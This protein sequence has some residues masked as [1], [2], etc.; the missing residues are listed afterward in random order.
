MP[1][2]PWIIVRNEAGYSVG[3]LVLRMSI[4][5]TDP[6]T[7]SITT[8]TF[9]HDLEGNMLFPVGTATAVARRMQLEPLD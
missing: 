8:Q 9:F 6:D 2:K 5:R 7:L 3:F 4:V 1:R